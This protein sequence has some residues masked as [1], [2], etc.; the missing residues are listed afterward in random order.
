MK[1]GE[2]H[3]VK[4]QEMVPILYHGTHSVARFFVAL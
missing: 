2:G 3:S 1:V 4:Y